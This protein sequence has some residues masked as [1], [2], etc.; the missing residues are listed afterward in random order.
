MRS[1]PLQIDVYA[2]VVCPWC[3]IGERRLEQALALHPDL[4]VERRWRPFQLQPDMPKDGMAWSLFIERKFGGATRA[5]SIFAHVTSIGA[6]D[7]I[8]LDFD[9]VATAPNT[10][11]AHRLILYAGRHGRTWEM[12]NAL[13]AAYFSDGRNLN[14]LD[15]LVAIGQQIG[16]NGEAVRTFLAS[17][18]G[19]AEVLASQNSASQIGVQG[20]PFFVFAEKYAISGAQPIDVFLRA[21]DMIAMQ[22]N[23]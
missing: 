1:E 19:V 21:L 17:D 16:L 22:H 4:E 8:N 10:V 2:D 15:Q 3:Y 23:D 9:R 13:F 14:D 11:D 7:G 5:R 20:V 18:G 6:A 12:A